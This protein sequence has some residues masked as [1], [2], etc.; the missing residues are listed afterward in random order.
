MITPVSLQEYL[1]SLKESGA[2][3]STRQHR[4][5][6]L[7]TFLKY[8]ADMDSSLAVYYLHTNT[9]AVKSAPVNAVVEY[10][11]EK[12]IRVLMEQPD[13]TTPK[14]QRDMFF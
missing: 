5:A 13:L 6:S 12:A 2:S 7:K 9:V 3:E 14:G 8:C 4:L 10:L 11:S 1:V